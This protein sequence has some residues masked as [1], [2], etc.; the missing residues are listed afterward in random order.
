MSE[1]TFESAAE[2]EQENPTFNSAS[3]FGAAFE[4]GQSSEAGSFWPSLYKE[5]PERERCGAVG[6]RSGGKPNDR[7]GATWVQ[8]G[9]LARPT[10][11]FQHLVEG[12]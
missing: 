11:F 4:T 1:K 2:I 9:L 10:H 3:P 5:K 6:R 7:I 8:C 12:T